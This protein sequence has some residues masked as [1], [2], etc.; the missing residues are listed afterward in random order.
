MKNYLTSQE[1]PIS[2]TPHQLIKSRVPVDAGRPAQF[3][4]NK[5]R[6]D[7]TTASWRDNAEN[8]VVEGWREAVAEVS[9]PRPFVELELS[10]RPRKLYEFP[11]GYSQNFG[12]ERYRLPE[13]LFDPAQY[14][15]RVS[16]TF[17]LVCTLYTLS[18]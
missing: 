12:V 7:R 15:D 11:T 14:I 5:D 16:A 6:S 13:I 1:P 8:K 9:A 10:T 18:D 17:V 3:T 4:L 2:L